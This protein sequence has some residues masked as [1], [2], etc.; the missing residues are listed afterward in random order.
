[1]KR[2]TREE[3]DNAK[4]FNA[5]AGADL[6]RGTI[7]E[8]PKIRLP[9]RGLMLFNIIYSKMTMILLRYWTLIFDYRVLI[10]KTSGN[11]LGKLHFN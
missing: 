5:A 2:P 4:G 7:F 8:F 1:M 6:V 9:R 10:V 3:R 11:L